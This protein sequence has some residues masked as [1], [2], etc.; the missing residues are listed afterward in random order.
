[1]T[2]RSRRR[3]LATA[4]ALLLG[5]TLSLVPAL[6][7]QASGRRSMPLHTLET[8][9]QG[10]FALSQQPFYPELEAVRA[11]WQQHQLGQVV[12]DS[13]RGT[14]LNFYALMAEVET[15]ATAISRAGAVDP[16]WSWS[17]PLQQQIKDTVALFDLAVG[18]LDA[19]RFPGSV[20]QDMAQESAL[21]LKEILDYVFSFSS[22]PINLPNSADLSQL[23][24][25]RGK[26]SNN[27]R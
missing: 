24:R 16:G 17:P 4:L 7:S 2:N 12:A 13:P 20:R 19:S 6:P 15:R 23:A 9:S 3:W 8:R 14:L 18:A 10:S 5:I 21:Q 25:S 26:A 27:W 22:G 11:A 1:M